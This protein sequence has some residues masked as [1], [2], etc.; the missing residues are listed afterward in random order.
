[1]D[2]ILRHMNGIDLANPPVE[3]ISDSSHAIRTQRKRAIAAAVAVFLCVLGWLACEIPKGTLTHTDELLTAER[4]R[5][6][7]SMGPWVVHYNFQRSFEKPPLQYWLTT[8][9]LPRLQNRTLAVRIW[10]LL[11]GGLTMVASGWLVFLVEPNR[12]WLIPLSLAMLASSP[13]FSPEA[14]RGFLDIGLTFFTIMAVIFAQLA[15]RQSAWW[16]AVAGVCWLGSLQKVPLPFLVWVVIL[17]ARMTSPVERS[18]LRRGWLPGSMVVAI[19]AMSI[20]PLIQVIG[21]DMSVREIFYKEVIVWTGPTGL[22]NR[23]YLAILI[24]LSTLGGACGLLSFLAAFVVLFSKKVRPSAGVREV[25]IVSLAVIGLAVVSN[26]RGVRY[27][28]PIV[29]CLCFLLALLFHRFL[30]QGPVIRFRATVLLI[31]VLS[32]D[33]VHSAITIERRQK[34]VPDEKLIAEKLGALQQP[35]TKA[36]LIKAEKSGGDLLWDSFY[37]FHGN[38]RFPVKSYTVDEMRSH[39]PEPPLIGA[40]VARDF[41]VIRDLYPSVQVELVRAQFICWQV[42][43]R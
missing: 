40:C 36:I 3:Q 10:P 23:P 42:D 8:L 28:V 15:R 21:Y 30:E 26:F 32:A 7:L 1:M 43:A 24:G 37:L 25:A 13:L 11:Y 31:I 38:C 9:T 5:E 41:P 14:S 12:P 18:G 20:W 17:L 34:N 16:L 19:G 6:M 4:S 22:G 29:P 27:I 39:P 33:F 2:Y 35:Q